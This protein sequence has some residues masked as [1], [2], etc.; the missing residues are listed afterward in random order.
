MKTERELMA[1][2][3]TTKVKELET[4]KRFM[5]R[6]QEYDCLTESSFVI[7]PHETTLA[8]MINVDEVSVE[9]NDEEVTTWL[10]R[11]CTVISDSDKQ[12]TISGW[13]LLK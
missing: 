2:A 5:M 9:I 10:S 8:L 13:K 1:I 7:F 12:T 3:T 4:I 11:Y 6:Q